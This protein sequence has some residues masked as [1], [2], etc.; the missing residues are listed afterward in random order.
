MELRLR[1]P[2]DLPINLDLLPAVDAHRLLAKLGEFLGRYSDVEG[3]M[4]PATDASRKVELSEE[5][6]TVRN[7]IEQTGLVTS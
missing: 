1:R 5:Y 6:T 2:R 4:I 7:V 3:L